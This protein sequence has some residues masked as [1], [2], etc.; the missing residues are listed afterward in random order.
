MSLGDVVEQSRG[1]HVLVL[2]ARREEM[3][4]DVE[5]VALVSDRHAAE[6]RR[7]AIRQRGFDEGT[8]VVGHRRPHVAPE[9][10]HAMDRPRARDASHRR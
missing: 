7:R 8:L 9:L 10:A 5:R 4:C 6:Q 2:D 1:E 3:L